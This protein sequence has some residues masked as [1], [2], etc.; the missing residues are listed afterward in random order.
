MTN[1]YSMYHFHHGHG[2]GLYGMTFLDAMKHELIRAPLIDLPLLSMT[3]V[4]MR[5]SG[6]VNNGGKYC[7]FSSQVKQER[8]PI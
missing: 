6:H 4:M 7:T 1:I 5:S 8:P 2:Q 3:T